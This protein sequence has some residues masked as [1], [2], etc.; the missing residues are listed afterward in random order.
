[1]TKNY[2]SLKF[3]AMII[4][5]FAGFTFASCGKEED[6]PGG[7]DPIIPPIGELTELKSPITENTTL[8]DLGLPIDY[9]FAGSTLFVQ[10]NAVLTIEPGVTIQFTST[11]D[12]GSL[13]INDG[14][15]IKAIGTAEKHIQFVGRNSAKG[16]WGTVQVNTNSDN[17]FKY[18]DFV[19]GGNGSF[20]TLSMRG[21]GNNSPRISVQYC[22]I[23][24][25]KKYGFDTYGNNFA[26]DAFDHNTIT[27]GDDA[28]V[29]L[30]NL[31]MAEK[32]DLT[33]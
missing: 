15:T 9:F 22:S 33:S 32:F 31:K 12:K 27:G 10:N 8:K 7:G 3:W 24:G 20:G 17:E 30:Y 25:S 5:L 29:Y 6:E 16:S 13:Q 2:F 14:A 26:I 23:T 21:S 28:P 18:C 19:N 1:M 11:G 4:A